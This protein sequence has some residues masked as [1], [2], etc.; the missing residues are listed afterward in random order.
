MSN[1][2]STT[3]ASLGERAAARLRRP[4]SSE[5]VPDSSQPGDTA[6]PMS[7]RQAR[8]ILSHTANL[9]QREIDAAERVVQAFRSK[10]PCFRYDAANGIPVGASGLACKPC[11]SLVW[12]EHEVDG[13][14]IWACASC[15]SPPMTDAEAATL[16]KTIATREASEAAARAAAVKAAHRPPREVL[17]EAHANLDEARKAHG[18]VASAA[19]SAAKAVGVARETLE[20]AEGALEAARMRATAARVEELMSPGTNPGTNP[21]TK[22]GP[23]SSGSLLAQTSAV[24]DASASLGAAQDA[25]LTIEANVRTLREKIPGLEN[26]VQAAVLA[27]IEDERGAQLVED[28]TR[29][30]DEFVAA[31]RGLAWLA[32]KG[33]RPKGS[34]FLLVCMDRTPAS[35][36][37]VWQDGGVS[38]EPLEDLF[39]QLAQ[40][41]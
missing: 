13:D 22:P 4:S 11:G 34:Q 1:V 8:A 33:V 16:R 41:G 26:R 5:Q 3:M 24:D 6:K 36:P 25:R 17:A 32:K 23:K 37:G 21:G 15:H 9:S 18:R 35:W 38:P 14:A 19:S 39:R 27:V 30:R 12:M 10:N 28:A 29:L 20:T 40:G 2:I 31:L 7:V